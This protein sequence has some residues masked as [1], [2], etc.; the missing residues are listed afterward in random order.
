MMEQLVILSETNEITRKLR[1]RRRQYA[2]LL[3][4]REQLWSRLTQD[5]QAM[6]DCR[7]LV[8]GKVYPGVEI[9]IGRT[10]M[11]VERAREAVLF[12]LKD[13]EIVVENL[14]AA[15]RGGHS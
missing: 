10:F 7:L 6:E 1:A 13:D 5:E 2:D 12:R 3:K 15:L 9:S 4:K 11:A 14:P 8:P